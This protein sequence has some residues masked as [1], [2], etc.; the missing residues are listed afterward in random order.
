MDNPSIQHS[1]KTVLKRGRWTL[2]SPF[3]LHRRHSRMRTRRAAALLG[4][5]LSPVLGPTYR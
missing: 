1:A 5:I 4:P 2:V 3:I